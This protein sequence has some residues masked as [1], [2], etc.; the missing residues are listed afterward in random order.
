M[1]PGILTKYNASAGSGKTFRL[2]GAYLDFL[3]RNSMSYRNILAV[4]FTN[5]AAA[6]MKERILL[7]LF[8]LSSGQDSDYLEHLKGLTGKSSEIIEREAHAN[9]EAILHDYSRFSVGTIDSFFQKILRSFARESGLQA[10]FNLIL[11]H[12]VILSD[13]VDEMMREAENDPVLLKWLTEYAYSEVQ[14]GKNWNLKNK[15]VELGG[16]I[17]KESFRLLNEAGNIVSSKEVLNTAVIQL[18][19]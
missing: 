17:F 16:E 2:T 1:V 4:T 5:K 10:G 13:A 15:I 12:S 6:E 7:S 14:S 8:R 18:N 9:L 3:F 11:D 19:R